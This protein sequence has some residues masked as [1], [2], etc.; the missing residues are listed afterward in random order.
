MASKKGKSN[1]VK[2]F[3]NFDL[4]D[5][6]YLKS[7]YKKKAH[8]FKLAKDMIDY[9]DHFKAQLN[10]EEVRR[11]ERNYN[12]YNGN[13]EEVEELTQSPDMSFKINGGKDNVNSGGARM[14]HYPFGESIARQIVSQ[15]GLNP[16]QP[17]V[18]DYSAKAA[19]SRRRNKAKKVGGWLQQTI[20]EPIRSQ[21]TNQ[22][23]QQYGVK[24]IFSLDE[25]QRQQMAADI[26]ARIQKEVPRDLMDDIASF[27]TGEEMQG[28]LFMNMLSKQQDL[29]NKFVGGFR[30]FVCA[31]RQGY[32][33]KTEN[34]KPIVRSLNPKYLTYGGSEHTEFI[35][36]GE[37]ASYE[38]YI[39]YTEILKRHS[40]L[41]K[42][43]LKNLMNLYG[44]VFTA[45]NDRN[46]RPNP[47]VE[48]N[49]LQNV[50]EGSLD[51]SGIDPRTREGQ[52]RIRG[53]YR[54]YSRGRE[55]FGIRDKY[56]TWM[57]DRK[58]IEVTR[59]VDGQKKVMYFDEHYEPND[60]IGDYEVREVWAPQVWHGHS[61]G[62]LGGVYSKVEPVPYQYNNLNDPFDVKLTIYGGEANYLHNNTSTTALIEPA[63]KWHYR[64][65]TLMRRVEEYEATNI[66][67]VLL[68]TASMKPEGWTW[69]E[70]FR[71]MKYGKF[72]P[73]NTHGEHIGQMDTNVFKSIDL[74][75]MMDIAGTLQQ[76]QHVEQ[77]IASAMHFNLAKLGQINPYMTTGNAKANIEASNNQ[78]YDYYKAHDRIINR[79]SNAL[80]A[81]ARVAYSETGINETVALD[82]YSVAELNV[83]DTLETFKSMG[84]YVVD[85]FRESQRMEMFKSKVEQLIMNGYGDLEDF[86][87]LFAVE[88]IAEIKQI[89]RRVSIK[90]REE[91]QQQ[92][93]ARS[94][95]IKTEKQ[96]E[97][98]L[99]ELKHELDMA[100][101]SKEA[102]IRLQLQEIDAEKFA[103]QFDINKD[104]LNDQVT[105]KEMQI[106]LDKWKTEKDAEIQKYKVDQRVQLEREKLA[107]MGK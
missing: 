27:K 57:W 30:D 106:E 61:L 34:G 31:G 56:I 23:L 2:S 100:K 43:E 8:D 73:I 84:I 25:Q 16:Y 96:L 92:S 71:S 21:I 19:S 89:A 48:M 69:A 15:V 55:G 107:K 85:S 9:Y 77:K 80:M 35:E 32:M 36:D 102:E 11:L 33:V 1:K 41:S 37:W 47:A 42:N 14:R 83:S 29:H 93:Q 91:S 62:E 18:I 46:K 101:Q 70:F 64:Y 3:K 59:I 67:K 22:Y 95:E 53:L 103:N 40:N 63:L 44:D 45:S 10:P 104:G 88:S 81:T 28:Q 98:E 97:R 24:D 12:Y 26:D 7:W 13:W 39:S 58:L 105:M 6:P 72:A 52:E 60:I 78:L 68:G 51:V 87:D 75:N 99:I 66:G 82:D 94:E 4:V 76:L 54:N 79:V 20:I 86:A 38:E 90:R 50:I 74:S 49:I 17:I 65:N 5:M